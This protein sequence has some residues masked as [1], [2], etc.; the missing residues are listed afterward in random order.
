MLKKSKKNKTN[1]LI[2]VKK[3]IKKFFY[4]LNSVHIKRLNKIPKKRR[5]TINK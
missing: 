5:Q 3:N 2:I 1:Q 4:L